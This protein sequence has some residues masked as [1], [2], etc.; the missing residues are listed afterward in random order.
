MAELDT[1]CVSFSFLTLYRFC[2]QS[3]VC[4]GLVTYLLEDF[5]KL[6]AYQNNMIYFPY[7]FEGLLIGARYWLK[8]KEN[9]A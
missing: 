6:M 4:F 3:Q 7:I 2:A 5:D 9:K 1:H 8:M